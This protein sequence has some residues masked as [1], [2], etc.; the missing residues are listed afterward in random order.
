MVTDTCF[1]GCCISMYLVLSF[2]LLN[3]VFYELVVLILFDYNVCALCRSF[4]ALR[5]GF[6]MAISSLNNISGFLYS[7]SVV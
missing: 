3:L 7:C 5:R 1:L 4:L 6:E 2:S